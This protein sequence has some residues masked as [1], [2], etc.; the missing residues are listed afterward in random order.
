MFIDQPDT[1]GSLTVGQIV[2]GIIFFVLGCL[3][4]LNSFI[5]GDDQLV[6]TIVCFVCS[7]IMFLPIKKLPL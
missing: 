5:T 6:F 2:T 1:I 3:Y 7:V 4:P